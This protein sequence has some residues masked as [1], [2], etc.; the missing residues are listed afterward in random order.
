MPRKG[1]ECIGFLDSDILGEVIHLISPHLFLSSIMQTTIN[2]QNVNLIYARSLGNVIGNGVDLPWHIP[3]D[4]KRFKELTMGGVVVMGRKTWESLPKKPL[5]GRINIILTSDQS[6]KDGDGVFYASSVGRVQALM[7]QN[8]DR[9]IWVIGGATVY[10]QFETLATHVYETVV[11]CNQIDGDTHY[12]F[13]K[14]PTERVSE[15]RQ[16]H[17]INGRNIDIVNR[18]LKIIK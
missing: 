16:S 12:H 2:K 11:M 6:E 7:R 5:A 3:G 10:A 14:Y 15:E 8:Q 13:N 17:L 9:D 18:V 4:L 1:H